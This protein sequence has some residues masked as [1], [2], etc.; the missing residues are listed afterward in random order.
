MYYFVLILNSEVY[1]FY[2]RIIYFSCAF[3]LLNQILHECNFIFFLIFQIS[4]MKLSNKL[5]IKT[6]EALNHIKLC[7][8]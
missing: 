5:F 2:Y 3:L 8:Y 7:E 1:Y 4:L 6:F